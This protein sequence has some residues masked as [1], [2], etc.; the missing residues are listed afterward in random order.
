MQM[1]ETL[2]RE[3]VS[4]FYMKTVDMLKHFSLPLSMISY[5]VSNV[6]GL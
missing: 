5:E 3:S 6:I 2:C 1:E 4:V